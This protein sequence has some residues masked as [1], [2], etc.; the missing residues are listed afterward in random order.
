MLM[1]ETRNTLRAMLVVGLGAAWDEAQRRAQPPEA[2][3]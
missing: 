1:P 2:T 3:E